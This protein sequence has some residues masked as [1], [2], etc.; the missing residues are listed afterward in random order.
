VPCQVRGNPN[1]SNADTGLF[2]TFTLVKRGRKKISGKQFSGNGHSVIRGLV[3]AGQWFAVGVG[4]YSRE[5]W[6]LSMS[7]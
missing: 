2:L 3:T 4:V 5:S 1:I 7:T 6:W